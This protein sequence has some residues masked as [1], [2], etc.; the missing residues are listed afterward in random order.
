MSQT[1]N[2]GAAIEAAQELNRTLEALIAKRGETAAQIAALQAQS[3]RL[4]RAPLPKAE[5]LANMHWSVDKL[6][7]RYS[8]SASW[9][10]VFEAFAHPKGFRPPSWGNTVDLSHAGSTK[11]EE[12]LSLQD[13]DFADARGEN[14]LQTIV[15]DGNVFLGFAAEEGLDAERA[16]FFFGDLIKQRITDHFDRLCPE[17]RSNSR[18]EKGDPVTSEERRA[19]VAANKA[20]IEQLTSELGTLELQIAELRAA[21]AGGV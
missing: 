14:G 19:K 11:H 18:P 1:I 17:P 2:V 8:Q 5:V 10:R 3:V 13:L 6:A 7:H 15:G 16:A 9:R 20:A 21:A 12:A 4:M